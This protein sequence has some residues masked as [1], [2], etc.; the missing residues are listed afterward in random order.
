MN[1]LV[2]IPIFFIF[3]F[4]DDFPKFR[5]LTL[6]ILFIGFSLLQVYMQFDSLGQEFNTTLNDAIQSIQLKRH[7]DVLN[8]TAANPWQYRILSEWIVE[9]FLRSIDTNNITSVTLVLGFLRFFQNLVI[10]ILTYQYFSRLKISKSSAVY[11]VILLAVSMLHVFYD[12]DLSFNTYF[13]VIFYLAGIIMI[14]DAHFSWLPILMV[15]ATLNRET[16]GMIPVVLIFYSI[17]NINM[18]YRKKAILFGLIGL[19]IWGLVSLL[20]RLYYSNVPL[21]KIGG[22]L[23]PGLE[24]IQYNLSVPQ[25]PILLFQTFGILPF[26]GLLQ[27]KKWHALVRTSVIILAPI[28]LI[29]HFFTGVW[30]ETR[31][32]LVL[33][34]IVIIPT[35][36][37]LINQFSHQIRIEGMQQQE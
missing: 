14:L 36:L 7:Y 18:L 16:S 26:V 12:S 34:V 8:G 19:L 20:L 23:S 28:W 32:F 25:L 4:T 35:V 1:I 27:Y 22:I 21:Y 17:Q 30:A 5:F 33:L 31:I 11:G 2:I 29:V 13:D 3:I 10:L 9:F 15:F 37:P 6:I 24:Y